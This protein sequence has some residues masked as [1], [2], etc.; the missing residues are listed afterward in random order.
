MTEKRGKTEK[1]LYPFNDAGCLEV[2][3]PSNKWYR[4]TSKEFRSYSYPRRISS[5]IKGEYITENYDG[6][7]YLY[8]TNIVVEI[9]EDNK[10]GILYPNDVD[11][12]ISKR[13]E[14]GRL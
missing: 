9:N 6:P 13:G 3:L 2:L 1:L 5:M 8:G 4:V 11:P 12:R 14:F 7:T 10:K